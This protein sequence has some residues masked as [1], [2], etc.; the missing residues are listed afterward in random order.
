MFSPEMDYAVGTADLGPYV[1]KVNKML[2]AKG[3][4]AMTEAQLKGQINQF[5]LFID[6]C[7]LY[8]IA[9]TEQNI[10]L[11]G[12]AKGE[13]ETAADMQ[14]FITVH[15][16]DQMRALSEPDRQRLGVMLFALYAGTELGHV[17]IAR[18]N[19]SEHEEGFRER[20]DAPPAPANAF[21][22]VLS[23]ATGVQFSTM[24]RQLRKS[25]GNSRFQVLRGGNF[26]L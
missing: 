15:G 20:F 12:R 23:P 24:G 5:K 10:H 25:S 4:P 16:T 11:L 14:S 19:A 17:E 1:T 2:A 8:G 13:Y 22:V 7:H 21:T 9:V 18:L 3:Q 26:A 6:L